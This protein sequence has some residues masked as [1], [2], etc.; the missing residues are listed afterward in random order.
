MM[1][2]CLL[3]KFVVLILC[4]AYHLH[5]ASYATVEPQL[6]LHVAHRLICEGLYC[7]QCSEVDIVS[8]GMPG[9]V[10]LGSSTSTFISDARRREMV[11]YVHFPRGKISPTHVVELII[12]I[13]LVS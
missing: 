10:E 5:D 6:R 8:H 7:C 9:T 11:S 1:V 12:I 13:L 3:P 4:T 2:L